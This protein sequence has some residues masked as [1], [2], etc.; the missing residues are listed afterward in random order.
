MARLFR[1]KQLGEG[2][3]F[4]KWLN[5]RFKKNKN[6]LKVTTGAT[7]SGK[8]Y[9]DL[10]QAELHYQI[11]LKRSFPPE[12]IC[13]SVGEVMTRLTSGEL[14]RGDIII[15]EE[16]GANLS[17]LDFQTKLS[18]MFSYVLQSFRSLNVGIFFNLPFSTMLNKTARL[19][20]HAHFVTS[21]IDYNNKTSIC[22]PFFLQVNQS[23]GK[24]YL[25][26]LRIRIQGKVRAIKRFNW[27]LPSPHLIDIYEKKKA[28]FLS[29]LTQEFKQHLDEIERDQRR[30]MSREELTD[31]QLEVYNLACKGLNSTQ[32]G[33]E[34]SKS[35]PTIREFLKIIKRKGFKIQIEQNSLAN[36]GLKAL[37]PPTPPLN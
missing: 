32:I 15:F 33:R 27:S 2:E 30:K 22:K 8:S 1:I 7:G 14:K 11:N 4:C 25:K 19:L 12:N 23:T 29:E 3:V 35:S 9:Q 28:K 13:F 16:A 20:L 31:K 37:N 6:V 36:E 17:A 5:N 24:V 21:G 18:K 26:Y 34:L 10:R